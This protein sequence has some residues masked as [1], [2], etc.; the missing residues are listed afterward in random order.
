MRTI[1]IEEFG[2]PEV[3]MVTERQTPP[4]VAGG[5]RAVG[6]DPLDGRVGPMP[7]RTPRS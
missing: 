1:A 3:R 4:P 6:V 7:R 2:A 5:T